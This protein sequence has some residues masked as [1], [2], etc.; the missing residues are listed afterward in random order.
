MQVDNVIKHSWSNI[1]LLVKE[2][3]KNVI[4]DLALPGGHNGATKEVAKVM[5][6]GNLK[7]RLKECRTPLIMLFLY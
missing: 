1:I 5:N 3:L 2:S 6:Y 7:A 4:I